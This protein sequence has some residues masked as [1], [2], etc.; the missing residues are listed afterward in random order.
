MACR[1]QTQPD[2]KIECEAT[3]TWESVSFRF[4]HPFRVCSDSEVMQEV[5]FL[6]KAKEEVAA[7]NRM[8]AAADTGPRLLD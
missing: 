2:S 6:A 4:S 5:G 8:A 7:L 3:P 1:S